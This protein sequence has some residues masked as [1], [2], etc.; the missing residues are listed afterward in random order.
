MKEKRDLGVKNEV[1]INQDTGEVKQFSVVLKEASDNGFHKVWLEDLAHILG[2]LGGGKTKVFQHILGNINPYSNEFGGT[3][4]EIS[5]KLGIDK[6]TVN[7]TINLLMEAD[8]LKKVRSGTYLVNSETLIQG[9]HTKR[10]GIMIK[11]RG[12]E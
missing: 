4:R 7:K 9:S 8:F 1:W 2:L 10:S 3:V 6:T 12:L 11:Y 5:E